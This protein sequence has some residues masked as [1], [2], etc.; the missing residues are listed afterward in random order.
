MVLALKKQS[1]RGDIRTTVE[2]LIKLLELKEFRENSISTAWLDSLIADHVTAEKPPSEL[3][4]VVAAVCRAH[5]DFSQRADDFTKS[6]E[7]GQ[8][9]PLDTSV[10]VFPVELIYN[11]MKYSF[12]ITR[13][14]ICLYRVRLVNE[15]SNSRSS[16]GVLVGLQCMADGALDAVEMA[17]CDRRLRR[18]DFNHVFLNL[19]SLVQIHIENVEAICR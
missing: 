19:I 12:L 6:L 18:T 1:I 17:I 8:L 4:V 13:A 5:S 16:P 11:D 7:R 3:A 14:D 10:V 15:A 9:P 2:Y